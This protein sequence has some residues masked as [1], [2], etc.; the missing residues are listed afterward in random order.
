MD[1]APY[2]GGKDVS[3]RLCEQDIVCNMNLLPGEPAK[4]AFSPRGIRLGVQ[5]MTRF[6]MGPDEMAQ[7]A[8][9]MKAALTKE[10]DVRSEVATLRER[11][12]DVHYGYS[13]SDLE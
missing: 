1:V 11:F 5:E 2:G 3:A 4:N 9:F 10:R 12:P 6:G 13:L 7:V 8:D